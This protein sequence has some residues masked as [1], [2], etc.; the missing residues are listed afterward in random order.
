[1]RIPLPSETVF[2]DIERSIKEYRKFSQRN[3]SEAIPDITIDQGMI[4]LFLDRYPELSQKEIAE[5]IFRDNASMTRMINIMVK[6][7]YLN[8]SINEQDR[9]RFHLVMTPK[10]KEVLTKLPPIIVNNRAQSLMG[11]SEEE[12]FQ[13]KTILKKITQNCTKLNAL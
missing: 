13:L 5:L 1:M 2:H 4:L 7:K 10:G 11:I 12:Q 9:R 6:N 8:R 3:I